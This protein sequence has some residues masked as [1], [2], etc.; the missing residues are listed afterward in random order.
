MP[1]RM[2]DFTGAFCCQAD[3][4]HLHIYS[5]IQDV[6]TSFIVSVIA[7]E[8]QVWTKKNTHLDKRNPQCFI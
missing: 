6:V 4:K 7:K 5:Y 2:A 8:V 1:L 3:V